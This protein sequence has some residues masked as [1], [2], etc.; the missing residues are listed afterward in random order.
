MELGVRSKHNTTTTWYVGQDLIIDADRQHPRISIPQ[1][2]RSLIIQNVRLGDGNIYECFAQLFSISE[3]QFVA[4]LVYT[5]PITKAS[6]QK[7]STGHATIAVQAGEHKDVTLTCTMKTEADERTVKSIDVDWRRNGKDLTDG[8]K[9]S[10]VTRI[11]TTCVPL[12]LP[13]KKC[14]LAIE[15]TVVVHA[16][17][18]EDNGDLTCHVTLV[19]TG[20]QDGTDHRFN[21]ESRISLHVLSEL[22]GS[23]STGVLTGFCWGGGS[24]GM[25]PQELPGTRGALKSILVNFGIHDTNL[26]QFLGGGGGRVPQCSHF[27]CDTR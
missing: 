15:S 8:E 20:A 14:R 13:D 22:G 19:A 23:T 25:P 4:V 17:G 3:S 26:I 7:R 21:L 9:T 6:N 11:N 18:P 27:L 12:V 2:N 16:L 1:E 5:P 10:V 24:E